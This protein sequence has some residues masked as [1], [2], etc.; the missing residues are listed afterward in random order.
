MGSGGGVSAGVAVAAAIFGGGADGLDIGGVVA[1]GI[2]SAIT[3]GGVRKAVV[4]SP[5]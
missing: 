4:L 3:G 2:D 5:G 1:A